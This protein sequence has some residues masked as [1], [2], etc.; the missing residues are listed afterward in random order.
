MDW[1]EKVTCDVGQSRYELAH[2]PSCSH[3][4]SSKVDG[5][6]TLSAPQMAGHTAWQLVGKWE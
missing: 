3:P 2:T 6:W 5:H 1:I 4:R